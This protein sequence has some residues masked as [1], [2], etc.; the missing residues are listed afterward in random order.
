MWGTV[1]IAFFLLFAMKTRLMFAKRILLIT[2][3]INVNFARI[4]GSARWRRAGSVQRRS[5]IHETYVY[6]F[7][8][9]W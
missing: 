4:A 3:Q 6:L 1:T 9:E 2:S 7:K 5:K 8:K